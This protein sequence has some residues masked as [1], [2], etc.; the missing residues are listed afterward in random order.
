MP[1][2]GCWQLRVAGVGVAGAGLGCAP[3]RAGTLEPALGQAYNNNPQLNA[4]RALVRATDEN[5]PTAL[6]GYRPRASINASAGTQA[7]AT[8]I[9]EIGSQTVPGSAASYFRQIGGNLPHG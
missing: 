6:A 7:L 9:R 3:V 4:Q 8:N 2:V 5:V 1:G